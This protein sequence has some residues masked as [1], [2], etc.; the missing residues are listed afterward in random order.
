MTQVSH[1]VRD[2]GVAANLSGARL[3]LSTPTAGGAFAA[4]ASTIDNTTND[5]RT[6]LPR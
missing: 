1:V 4:Y 5:P 6:L 2:L 3:V